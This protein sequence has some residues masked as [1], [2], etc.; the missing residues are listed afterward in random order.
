MSPCIQNSLHKSTFILSLTF[1]S[2][3]QNVTPNQA[4]NIGEKR[5]VSYDIGEINLVF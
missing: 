3:Q 5:S 4:S 2:S 1:E